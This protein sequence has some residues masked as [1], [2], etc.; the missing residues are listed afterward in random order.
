MTTTAPSPTRSS[1]R[2]ASRTRSTTPASR[3]GAS[4]RSW[5]TSK[6][7][8][9]RPSTSRAGMSSRVA[10]EARREPRRIPF[11][12]E[13]ARLMPTVATRLRRDFV[14]V[15]CLVRAH[16]ILHQATR[17][18]DDRGRSSRPS[19]TTP[20]CTSCSTTS[21]RRPWTRASPLRHGTPWKPCAPPRGRGRTHLGQE[22]RRPARR[23]RSA[24]YDRVRRALVAGFLVNVAKENERGLKI[25]LGADLPAGGRSCPNRTIVRSRPDGAPGQLSGSTVRDSEGCPVVR[26]VQVPLGRRRRAVSARPTAAERLEN[27]DALLSRVRT[28]ASSAS[29]AAPS[30]LSSARSRHRV[31]GLQQAARRACSDYLALARALHL[32]RLD[33]GEEESRSPQTAVANSADLSEGEQRSRRVVAVG[34]VGP[35]AYNPRVAPLRSSALRSSAP[36]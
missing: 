6:R 7:A 32:R 29:S 11:M 18:R 2:A 12:R 23:R 36:A 8:S 3:P 4:P 33:A 15:L 27:P 13:L 28:C 30:T 10:R 19:P 14:S 1:R 25:A 31:R 17:E 20:P 22:D 5:P 24:T 35:P 9:P 26:V 21:S 16:A 34:S